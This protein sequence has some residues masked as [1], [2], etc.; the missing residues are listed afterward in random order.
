LEQEEPGLISLICEKLE[1]MFEKLETVCSS[2]L[3]TKFD[4][5]EVE[6]MRT[7]VGF[8]YASY[9]NL[10]LESLV[11]S[12]KMECKC[13]LEETD[14]SRSLLGRVREDTERTRMSKSGSSL[15]TERDEEKL[16][17]FLFKLRSFQSRLDELDRKFIQLTFRFYEY[18]T[19]SE[20]TNT[21]GDKTLEENY[22]AELEK[23]QTNGYFPIL[24]SKV[25]RNFLVKQFEYK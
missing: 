5:W 2:K 19:T 8:T 4:V 1:E 25:Q 15:N 3:A 17:D 13:F 24:I 12:I 7:S 14:A 21:T 23:F 20:G 18:S 10:S 9:T 11:K 6:R 16:D 22:A